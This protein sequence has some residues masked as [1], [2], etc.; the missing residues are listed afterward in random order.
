M[1]K[2]I[3]NSKRGFTL[4]EILTATV[5]AGICITVVLKIAIDILN[6]WNRSVEYGTIYAE[7]SQGLELIAEDLEQ[8]QFPIL[9]GEVQGKE[10]NWLGFTAFRNEDRI[11]IFYTK[12]GSELGKVN[13][14]RAVLPYSDNAESQIDDY[15]RTTKPEDECKVCNNI[16][17]FHADFFS[18]AEEKISSVYIPE[19]QF[20]DIVLI[21]HLEDE[22]KPL[23]RSVTFIA[24]ALN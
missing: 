8:A 20:A 17:A 19:A 24:K 3:N 13:L 1:S 22:S 2:F 10:I 23:S 15:L 6:T 18:A 7:A 16:E 4:I 21:P 14:Y 11:I 9:R 5:I 12:K